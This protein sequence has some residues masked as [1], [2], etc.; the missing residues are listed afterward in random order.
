MSI[1]KNLNAKQKA[2]LA[3]SPEIKALMTALP[4]LSG[5]Q[6]KIINYVGE[7]ADEQ[8]AKT[9]AVEITTLLQQFPNVSRYAAARPVAPKCAPPKVWD[10]ITEACV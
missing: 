10:P 4:A 5:M 3:N 1:R 6:V 7:A 9:R 2:V 8:Q